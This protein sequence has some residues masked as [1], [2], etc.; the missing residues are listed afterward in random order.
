MDHAL[1][2]VQEV[3]AHLAKVRS[4]GERAERA[5]AVTLQF[6]HVAYRG[7]PGCDSFGGTTFGC[8]S[9]LTGV[10][11]S[12]TF[13]SISSC[14]RYSLVVRNPRSPLSEVMAKTRELLQA[15]LADLKVQAD[16][17]AQ[18]S[19]DAVNRKGARLGQRLLML[20]GK[21][22]QAPQPTPF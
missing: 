21:W 1:Q 7:A 22:N 9:P 18:A 17:A 16:D 10:L 13:S 4:G 12:D 8:T 2:E 3:P 11:D 6:V 15:R 5:C 14:F 20:S 19:E